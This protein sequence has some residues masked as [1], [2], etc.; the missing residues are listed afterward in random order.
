METLKSEAIKAISTLHDTATI[1]DMMYRLFVIDKVRK[2][3]AAVEDDELISAKDL[4]D[5]INSW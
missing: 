1:E 2:A 5:E 4:M 3:Q